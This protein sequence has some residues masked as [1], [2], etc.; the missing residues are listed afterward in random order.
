MRV[1]GFILTRTNIRR[2]L[3]SGPARQITS[4][5]ESARFPA[6]LDRR[7]LSSETGGFVFG[8]FMRNFGKN[9]FI[10][11]RYQY[12]RLNARRDEDAPPGGFVIPDLELRSTTAAI[13]FHVQRDLRNSTYYPTKGSLFDFKAD[14]FA[15]PLGSN[16]NY[17]TYSVAYNGYHSVGR[18]QVLAYRAMACSVSDRTPFS[19]FAFSAHAATF[20]A[21][22]QAS[23]RTGECSRHRPNTGVNCPGD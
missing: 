14:F 8:E 5:L 2:H 10:G 20:A 21:I 18:Q 16:R 11:P 7:S 3:D 19:I 1:R 6:T 23:F 12:R 4:S 22:P 13:G 9:I 17:Q 15:K